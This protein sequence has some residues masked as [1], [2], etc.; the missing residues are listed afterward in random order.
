M[1]SP[2]IHFFCIE[3]LCAEE[4]DGSTC[5]KAQ[6]VACTDVTNQTERK[7]LLRK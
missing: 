2:M 4:N 5:I 6:L 7:K 1:I 3:V